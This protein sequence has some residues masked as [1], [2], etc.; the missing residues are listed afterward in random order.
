MVIVRHSSGALYKRG[1]SSTHLAVKATQSRHAC[2]EIFVI[3]IEAVINYRHPNPGTT[4]GVPGFLCAHIRTSCTSVLAGVVPLPLLC[5]AWVVR[6][7]PLRNMLDKGR[8]SQSE[9]FVPM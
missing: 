1:S 2:S 6:R 8:F 5:K 7:E 9:S 3:R 4:R